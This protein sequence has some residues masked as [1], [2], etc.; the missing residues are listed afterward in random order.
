MSQLSQI[1]QQNASASEE[2]AATAEEMSG[3]AQQ[4]QQTIDFF[5]VETNISDSQRKPVTNRVAADSSKVTRPAKAK[6]RSAMPTLAG[7][8]NEAE[9]ARF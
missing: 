3:Q 4:L 5:K 6:T 2:L 1:T 8:P 9:F 7:I